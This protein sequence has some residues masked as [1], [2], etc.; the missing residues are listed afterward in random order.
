MIPLKAQAIQTALMGDWDNA[1]ILNQTILQEDPNDIDTLNRLG[2]AF[3]SIGSIKEAKDIYQKVLT[4]D[5]LN[6]IALR[7]L[8][9]LNN[10]NTPAKGSNGNF[11]KLMTNLFIEEPGKTKVIELINVADKKVITPLRSGEGL[12]LSVKRM[13]IFVLDSQ[14]QYIGMLPDD[15]GRR[16]IKFIEGGNTY[17]A[18]VKTVDNNK[19]SIFARELHRTPRFKHEPSFLSSLSKFNL[20]KMKISPQDKHADDEDSYS[21]AEEESL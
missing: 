3:S 9:R 5:T 10:G 21:P 20:D 7:N 13:K 14:K 8:K 17:E 11:T 15:I 6:P 19:V 2:Y 4:L 12:Q 16:L 18:Y 1:I